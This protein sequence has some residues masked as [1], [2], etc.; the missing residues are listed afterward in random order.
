MAAS[1]DDEG[2]GVLG[3]LGFRRPAPSKLLAILRKAWKLSQAWP[4][5]LVPTH[6]GKSKQVWLGHAWAGRT[7]GLPLCETILVPEYTGGQG[8]EVLLVL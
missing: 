1:G 2:T 6:V 7:S 5:Q 8:D 3:S 4:V